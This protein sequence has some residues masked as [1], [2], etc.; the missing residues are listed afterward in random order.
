MRV[1]GCGLRARIDFAKHQRL[2][3]KSKVEVEVE[4]EVEVKREKLKVETHHHNPLLLTFS[5]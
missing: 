5:F 2:I 4:V 1:A 3:A